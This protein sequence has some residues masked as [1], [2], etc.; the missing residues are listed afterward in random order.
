M[1]TFNRFVVISFMA[2]LLALVMTGS[3]VLFAQEKMPFVNHAGVELEAKINEKTGTAVRIYGIREHVDIYGL[4]IEQL[5]SLTVLEIGV[6][7]INAYSEQLRV[8]DQDIKLRKLETDGSWWFADYK[9][10]FQD[11]AVKYSEIGF[12]ID[13]AGY[14]VTLG[15]YAYPDITK[16]SSAQLSKNEAITIAQSEFAEDNPELVTD[17]EL[18]ILPVSD[19]SKYTYFLSWEITLRSYR[20]VKNITYYVDA[21]TG[22]I[23]RWVDNVRDNNI[24]GNISG[25]YWPKRTYDSPVTD[26]FFSRIR[27]SNAAGQVAN[28]LSDYNGNY[29]T[30]SLAWT[31][32]I[33]EINLANSWIQVRDNADDG[34]PVT[35]VMSGYPGEYDYQ[36]NAFD[37]T[38]VHWHATV[39][40]DFFKSPP[41]N[42]SGMDYQMRGYINSGSGINGLADGTNIYFGSQGGQQWARSSDVVYHE[43]TH[44]V[45]NKIYSG[46][47]EPNDLNYGTEAYAMDEGIPDYFAA[48]KNS[49]PAFAHDVGLWYRNLNNNLKYPD[50][51]DPEDIAGNQHLNGRIISGALWRSRQTIGNPTVANNLAFK[52]LQATPRARNFSDYLYNVYIINDGQYN[53]QYFSQIKDS[54][55]HHG[56]TTTPPPLPIYIDGPSWVQH[57]G[58]YTAV[59]SSGSGNYSYAW[60]ENDIYLGSSSGVT[61]CPMGQHSILRLEVTDNLLDRYGTTQRYIIKG[62]EGEEPMV[63]DLYYEIEHPTEYNI[64]DNYPNPFNPITTIRYNI[65][66]PSTVSLIIYDIT[67]REVR[68]LVDGTVEPGYHTAVWDGTGI[69]GKTVSSGVYIYRFT[70]VPANDSSHEGITTVR[71][72]VFTK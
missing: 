20:P 46:W 63:A 45:I 65:P 53:G 57:C 18:L 16:I 56:I 60:F 5:D 70:A 49:D 64:F 61:V 31:W 14:V 28:V 24:Y 43:Y 29:S 32:Y 30:G 44:N 51:F 7:I 38:N 71:K 22:T 62:E 33:V 8:T 27:V 58:N 39:M 4:S 1:I 37:G 66:E 55:A 6:D 47:I 40:H 54:F 36:W 19:G 72:M 48:T 52:A 21:Q 59:V 11:I 9:Q 42:Y 69:S 23:L 3:N 25:S 41:F 15:A 10:Y 34:N 68:R 26:P 17:P 67:G 50:N 35:H 2:L 13:P 12:S